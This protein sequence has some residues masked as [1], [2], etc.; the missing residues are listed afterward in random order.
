M[1][2]NVLAFFFLFLLLV[3]GV[4][5][6]QYQFY[7]TL[8]SVPVGEARTIVLGT[9]HKD[10]IPAIDE[11]EFESVLAAERELFSLKREVAT[12]KSDHAGLKNLIEQE[13]EVVANHLHHVQAL[14]ADRLPQF[15]AD[16]AKRELLKLQRE[17]AALQ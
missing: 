11:P 12:L 5:W 8:I 13:I 10:D 14:A 3:G 15:E 7:R 4:F 9:S 17:L 6:Y 1:S 16:R 2:R